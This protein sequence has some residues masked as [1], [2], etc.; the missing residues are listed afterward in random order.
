MGRIRSEV[1][2]RMREIRYGRGYMRGADTD[3]RT[4]YYFFISP[5]TPVPA[6]QL[7]IGIG[8]GLSLLLGGV[9][10]S[11]SSPLNPLSLL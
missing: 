8:W 2:R 7:E 11:F 5:L 6:T 4:D 1:E 9:L 10:L 3:K